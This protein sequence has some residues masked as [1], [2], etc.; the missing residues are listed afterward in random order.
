MMSRN[1]ASSLLSGF[2]AVAGS[3]NQFMK[4]RAALDQ[5]RL[6]MEQADALERV[7]DAED[8]RQ[9]S[10]QFFSSGLGVESLKISGGSS[11]SFFQVAPTAL[12]SESQR[13]DLENLLLNNNTTSL[14][15]DE[16]GNVRRAKGITIRPAAAV[17]PVRPEN[18]GKYVVEVLREDG[19]KGIVTNM[20]SSDPN[21]QVRFFTKDEIF[22]YA[23]DTVNSL[24]VKAGD[25]ILQGRL[26]G[27][28]AEETVR[29]AGLA[30]AEKLAQVKPALAQEYL[31]SFAAMDYND[32]VDELRDLGVDVDALLANQ[33]KNT[34]AGQLGGAPTP[35]QERATEANTRLTAARA[36]DYGKGKPGNKK[37]ADALRP[38]KE[39]LDA[40]LE[41][42]PEIA[43]LREQQEGLKTDKAGNRR[44]SK[45]EREIEAKKAEIVKGLPTASITSQSQGSI[46]GANGQ[47]I[48]LTEDSIRTALKDRLLRPTEEDYSFMRSRLN[49]LG[50]TSYSE[51]ITAAREGRM[52]SDDR[53]R[54][55]AMIAAA[56]PTLTAGSSKAKNPIDAFNEVLY[57]LTPR[58]QQLDEDKFGLDVDEFRNKLAEDFG[59]ASETVLE[60]VAKQSAALFDEN[61]RYKSSGDMNLRESADVVD[62]IATRSTIP[63][64]IGAANSRAF[65][66]VLANDLAGLAQTEGAANWGDFFMQWFQRDTQQVIGGFQDRMRL[67]TEGGVK[68]IVFKN[69]DGTTDQNFTIPFSDL[70]S[71][72][73]N[74]TLQLLE[75]QI[76][77]E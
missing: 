62:R 25:D 56:Q 8:A 6:R 15:E 63:G 50:V 32:Q 9:T 67:R 7:N 61:S 24:R 49:E 4:N 18:E 43:A 47:Q 16:E 48:Q 39:E 68:A 53:I 34:P 52:P 2:A 74:K 12:E 40:A 35:Y 26:M 45:I 66:R 69:A 70:K 1:A 3:G 13:Q 57:N 23:T 20:R 36:V 27:L 37:K 59:T 75:T 31:S 14:Y 5:S 41:E 46:S 17:G 76:Q 60:D 21:D 55:A 54:F 73:S 19:N 22:G 30:E 77:P 29:A 42:Y 38:I 51:A 33:V 44:R 64:Q 71:R 10:N 72:Y 11:G 28:S 65:Y 58:K